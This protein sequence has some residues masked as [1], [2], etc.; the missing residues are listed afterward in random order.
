MVPMTAVK[1]IKFGCIISTPA[2]VSLDKGQIS[3]CSSI[4]SQKS[5]CHGYGISHSKLKA[6]YH[7]QWIAAEDSLAKEG[8]QGSFEVQSILYC[9]YMPNQNNAAYGLPSQYKL[10]LLFGSNIKQ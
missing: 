2:P 3:I 7:H 4:I 5:Q 6:C 8:Q 9:N 1:V 10:N